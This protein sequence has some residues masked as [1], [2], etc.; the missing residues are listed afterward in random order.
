[1]SDMDLG[2]PFLVAIE[3][4]LTARMPSVPVYLS[5]VTGTDDEL[6]Y[7]YLVAWPIPPSRF[8]A[9]LAGTLVPGDCRLQL[10]GVGL[11]PS[12]VTA[13]LG[14]ASSALVGRRPV[15]PGWQCGYIREIPVNQPVTE[16]AQALTGGGSTFRSWSQ[17]RMIA[18]PGRSTSP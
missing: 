17:Y 15:I 13:V 14:R 10:T 4:L 2:Q 6:D 5:G 18:D 11:D 7:P 9:N 3:A 1:M 16:N 8:I 12:S